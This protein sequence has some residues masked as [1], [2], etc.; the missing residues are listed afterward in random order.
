MNI[1]NPN[2]IINSF[3]PNG[4]NN[5]IFDIT[6]ESFS[7]VTDIDRINLAVTF[8]S[9]NPN[10]RVVCNGS[11][12]IDSA[13]IIKSNVTLVNNG[14]IKM[15]SGMKDNMIRSDV[16]TV[17]NPLKNIKIK[18]T[19]IFQ[20]SSDT[21][22][23]DAPSGVGAESWRSIGILLANCIDFEIEGITMKNTHSWGMCM[24]Q[25]RFGSI[26]NIHF[27]DDGTKTNQDGINIRRGSH[28]IVIENISGATYDDII[29]ITNLL[30]RNDTN[31]LSTTIYET[32]K[33]NFDMYDIIIRNINRVTPPKYT[34][35]SITPPH[36]S[37]GILLLCEDG[38]KI[39]N[40]TIDGVIGYSQ[41]HLGYTLTAYWQATQA[42]VND[43]FNITIS[44]TGDA[45]IYTNRPI[46]NCSLINVASK[47]I[48]NTYN[49]VAFQTGSLNVT[50]KYFN[51]NFEFFAT[52]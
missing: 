24:E 27:D 11:Y 23:G 17:G 4:K 40:V 32:G 39:S 46:K 12:L 43:M 21:W 9:A 19:G 48:T 38:L 7:G 30:V 51:A 20:G 1:Y 36:Y 44:N 49:S 14:L 41:I 26:K 50:R 22:G 16:T 35:P 8:A 10:C 42:T 28:H 37:G 33:S 52:V 6:P 18:G 13:I 47:D 15:N 25:S 45:P 29:A 2:I 3:T 5:L 34:F 31:Y